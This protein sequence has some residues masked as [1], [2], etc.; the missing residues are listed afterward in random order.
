MDRG[1]LD[2]PYGEGKDMRGGSDADWPLLNALLNAASG[3]TGINID[4]GAA[5]GVRYSLGTSYVVVADGTPEMAER[6]ARLLTNDSGIG[7]ARDANAGY[8][9]AVEFARGAG[10]TI[11]M[12]ASTTGSSL[13]LSDEEPD[14]ESDKQPYKTDR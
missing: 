5:E 11:P 8:S 10:I 7:V 4:N 13:S 9:E 12:P 14:E 1:S 3:A 2:S 6:I